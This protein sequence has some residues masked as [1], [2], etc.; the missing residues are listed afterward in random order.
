MPIWACHPKPKDGE[1]LSSW[2][3]RLASSAGMPVVEFCKTTLSISNPNLRLI[4][5]NPEAS[6]LLTLSEGTGVSIQ[7][8]QEAS[9]QTEEGYVFSQF[10]TGETVWHIPSLTNKSKTHKYTTGMAYCPACF[11]EDET[12]FYRKI[13]SFAY[14]SICPI[15]RIPLRN[16]CPH[17]GKPYSHLQPIAQKLVD[18]NLPVSACWSCG[19]HIGDP[20]TASSWGGD[21]LE[22]ALSIQ[23]KLIS[24]ISQGAFLIPNCEPIHSRSYLDV[25]HCIANSLSNGRDASIRSRYIGRAMGLEIEQYQSN[26]KIFDA[27]DIEHLQAENQ[28]ILL[29]L[30]YWLMEDWPRRLLRY[31]DKFELDHNRIFGSIDKSYWFLSSA[32]PLLQSKPKELRSDEEILSATIILRSKLKRPVSTGEV[33]E[34]MTL[35][36]VIDHTPERKAAKKAAQNWHQNFVSKWH[37]D[38]Q[39]RKKRRLAKIISWSQSKAFLENRTYLKIERNTES[40]PLAENTQYESG[41]NKK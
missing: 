18:P 26:Q 27:Q 36:R 10:G 3:V 8:V 17:C 23:D 7:R 37:A 28:T 14:Y 12:A 35:G 25:M 40:T 1:L 41:E 16:A 31:I 15:H 30:S 38:I 19:K 13:W 5:R 2:I 21:F 39:A 22:R 20:P 24:S 33:S 29:C 9:L 32:L 11:H 6:I 4:D 34:F